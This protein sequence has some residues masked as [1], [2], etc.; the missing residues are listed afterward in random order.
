MQNLGRMGKLIDITHRLTSPTFRNAERGTCYN[1]PVTDINDSLDVRA[2]CA[3]LTGIR[4]I[5]PTQVMMRKAELEYLR[6]RI[7][8]NR[9]LERTDLILLRDVADKAFHL[10][11][12]GAHVKSLYQV[13]LKHLP[14]DWL[15]H[16][17]LGKYYAYCER[18]DTLALPL[19]NTALRYA[20]QTCAAEVCH[21][22]ALQYARKGDFKSAKASIDAKY[23]AFDKGLEIK[24]ELMA[25]YVKGNAWSEAIENGLAIRE[26]LECHTSAPSDNSGNHKLWYTRCMNYLAQSYVALNDTSRAED[27]LDDLMI[28]PLFHDSFDEYHP[29]VLG[30]FE[31][32]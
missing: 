11:D 14:N 27:V 32:G 26:S 21:E 6:Y 1:N 20:P 28:S 16:F 30:L 8:S 29:S 4:D 18:D 9:Q 5:L 17:S 15:S 12:G 23:E 19:F 10:V 25:I 7:E 31:K 3:A 22:L 13:V 24:I 2:S